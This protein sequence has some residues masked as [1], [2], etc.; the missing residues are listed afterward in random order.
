MNTTL[1]KIREHDPC[2]SGWTTLLKSL[3]KT[4]ADDEPLSFKYILNSV[5]I[6]D[7]VWCL[8]TQEYKDICLFNADIAESTLSIFEKKHPNDDRPRKAIEGI[9]MFKSGDIT[10]EDLSSL[11]LYASDAACASYTVSAY[12]AADAASDAANTSAFDAATSAF[13]TAADSSASASASRGAY[14]A[15]SAARKKQWDLI[16][17]LFIKHFC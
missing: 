2:H 17:K 14:D 1:N 13:D 5:G 12:A 9:R 10:A 16:E 8:R 11:S 15:T 4:S 7:A 3:G 6:K